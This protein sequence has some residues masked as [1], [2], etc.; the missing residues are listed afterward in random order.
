MLPW[1]NFIK[2]M[3]M[4]K[5]CLITSIF[6]PFPKDV[7]DLSGGSEIASEIF[8]N[9][10]RS[11]GVEVDVVSMDY[12]NPVPNDPKYVTR[13]GRYYPYLLM[14]SKISETQF[15]YKEFFR[16]LIFLRIVSQ[17]RKTKPDIVII[18]KTLQFSLAPMIAARLIRIPYIIRYDWLCPTN[19]KPDLCTL[20][21]R[22]HCADCIQQTTG[23]SI[24]K[25]GK[26]ITGGFFVPM[27]ILKRFLW[28]QA[29]AIIPVSEFHKKFIMSF[30]IR[31]DIITILPNIIPVKS[32]EKV[33][34]ELKRKF[35]TD[36]YFTILYV[37]RL[38]PEK[39]VEILIDAFNL[40][41]HRKK[42]KLLIA[43]AGR[44][45][46]T[47]KKISKKDNDI[48]FLERV[49]HEDLG[50]YYALCDLIAIPSIVPEGHPVVAEEA[51]SLG[52]TII[53]FD[54]GGLQEIF[55]EYPH[56]INVKE[57]SVTSLSNAIA[58]HIEKEGC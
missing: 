41:R 4:K 39:G 26:I 55:K 36:G 8:V 57:I 19:P 13:V 2:N 33:V 47:V 51:M 14:D 31:D 58:E 7:T 20:K 18:G 25:I 49:P 9:E 44:L 1:A 21:D 12:I 38:E 54:I 28:N 3:N 52:K 24:P 10:L 50:N 23:K 29:E 37:G 53:G 34:D 40:A 42:I 46:E 35:E 22:F 16:P 27:S 17:L 6:P 15:V 43:G 30:G 45:S 5:V 56:S 48:I 32:D 11:K